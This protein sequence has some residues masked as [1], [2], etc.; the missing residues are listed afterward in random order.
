[1]KNSRCNQL[2]TG[3]GDFIYRKEMKRKKSVKGGESLW[4]IK[5]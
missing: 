3:Y 5:N 2:V 4:E 1:M